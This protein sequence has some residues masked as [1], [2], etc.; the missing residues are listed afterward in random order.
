MYVCKNK[1]EKKKK[2]KKEC[3]VRKTQRETTPRCSAKSIPQPLLPIEFN[4]ATI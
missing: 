3:K 2:K 4:Q 1:K